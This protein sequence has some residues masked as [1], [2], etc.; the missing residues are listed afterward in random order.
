MP[1]ERVDARVERFGRGTRDVAV[2]DKRHGVRVAS[3]PVQLTRQCAITSPEDPTEKQS[4]RGGRSRFLH[5]VC[6]YNN[7][8]TFTLN[9]I[10]LANRQAT[11][12]VP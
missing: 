9:G 2:S 6:L 1:L 12:V 3:L 5:P 11:A 8:A 10:V 4:W 7:T